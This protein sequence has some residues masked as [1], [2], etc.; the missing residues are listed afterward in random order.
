MD[1]NTN[2]KISAAIAAN[3]ADEQ[4]AIQ[5]YYQLLELIT[6]PT[7]QATIKEIISDEKNHSDLLTKLVLK[8]DSNIPEAID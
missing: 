2:Y 5:G 8:Y 7:D 6:D 1:D 3:N 4:Q